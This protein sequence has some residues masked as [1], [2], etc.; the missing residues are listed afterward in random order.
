[1]KAIFDFIAAWLALPEPEITVTPSDL[2]PRRLNIEIKTHVINPTHIA[3]FKD[4]S[5]GVYENDCLIAS[6]P[7]IVYA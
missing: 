1:M 6:S 4:G 7:V 3:L 5:I 2:D